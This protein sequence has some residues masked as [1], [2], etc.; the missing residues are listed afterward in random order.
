MCLDVLFWYNGPNFID[1]V[2][3]EKH[4]VRQLWA[5]KSFVISSTILPTWINLNFAPCN[6]PIF[7]YKFCKITNYIVYERLKI[8]QNILLVFW[9][10]KCIDHK[11]AIFHN[12]ELLYVIGLNRASTSVNLIKTEFQRARCTMISRDNF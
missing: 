7:F 1:A 5:W 8:F 9:N 4:V 12:F 6:L 11:M 3:L 2:R 10:L